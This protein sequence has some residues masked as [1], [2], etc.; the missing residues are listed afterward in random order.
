MNYDGAPDLEFGGGNTKIDPSVT[1]G[2]YTD[3]T[4]HDQ[5]KP[6]LNRCLQPYLQGAVSCPQK[7]TA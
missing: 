3:N 5:T 6:V 1:R 4:L 2:K 7:V